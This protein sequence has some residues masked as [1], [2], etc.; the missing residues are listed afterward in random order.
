MVLDAGNVLVSD[1][2]NINIEAA[3][4]RKLEAA[5]AA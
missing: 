3:V 5:V 1:K 2:I 4:Q